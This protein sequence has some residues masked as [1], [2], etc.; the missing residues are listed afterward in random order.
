MS[1]LSI[2]GV[3][4]DRSVDQKWSAISSASCAAQVGVTCLLSLMTTAIVRIDMSRFDPTHPA[5]ARL[6]LARFLI[7]EA[8]NRGL[9]H[10][11]KHYLM[12]TAL[13]LMHQAQT[14]ID[15]ESISV[16]ERH[17]VKDLDPSEIPF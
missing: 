17:E 10:G 12:Q 11:E 9:T 7:S 13:F 15:S 3:K 16:L 1:D 4:M 6:K 14:M 5:A 2:V 8:D